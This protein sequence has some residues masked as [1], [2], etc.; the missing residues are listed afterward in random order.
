[1]LLCSMTLFAQHPGHG[2]MDKK[3]A[4]IEKM[5]NFSPEQHA[6]L[7]SKR[8]TLALNLNENQQQAVKNL[9]MEKATKRKAQRQDKDEPSKLTSEERYQ[10]KVNKLDDQIAFKNGMQSI[11]NKDQ[12]LKWEQLN[13]ERSKRR[14]KKRHKTRDREQRKKI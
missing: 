12:F 8:L 5:K 6:E 10:L 11:L 13:K 14:G 3:Q 2:K 4:S 9:V 7:E 1:M